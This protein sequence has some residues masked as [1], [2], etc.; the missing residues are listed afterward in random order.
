MSKTIIWAT[1]GSETADR[2]LPYVR[3]LGAKPDATVVVVHSE[4][5]LVGPRVMGEVPLH[6]DE[7]DLKAK[8]ERQVHELEEQG[9]HVSLR[10]VQGG[11]PGAAHAIADVARELGADVIAVGTR[12]H[13][14]VVGLLL[15]SVTQ[16]LLHIAPCPVFVVPTAS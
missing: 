7:P 12:G 2:C 10:L 4:D 3:S 14:P 15:G 9:V 13:S 11:A 16:R 8:V 5:Y 1:D 6:A